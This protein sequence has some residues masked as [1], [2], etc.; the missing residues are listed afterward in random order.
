[1]AGLYSL[2]KGAR[3]QHEVLSRECRTDQYFTNKGWLHL[4]RTPRGF[5]SSLGMR[6]ALEQYG[7]GFDCVDKPE[8]A[9]LEPGLKPIFHS[10][11][12]IRDAAT[13][14]D[15]GA[16]SEALMVRF[17]AQGG[18][19]VHDHV[20]GI[21]PADSGW[22]VVLKQGRIETW[23]LVIAMGVNSGDLLKS[24]GLDVPLYAE[25]GYHQHFVPGGDHRLNRSIFDVESSYVMSPM[26]AG[27]R[28]TSGIEWAKAD[29]KPTPKQL[30]RIVP[31]ARQA[32]ELG[33]A[34]EVEP[35]LGCRPQTADS[36][37]MIG[38]AKPGL[39]VNAGHGHMGFNLGPVSGKVLAQTI[40]GEEPEI[41]LT[42]YSPWRFQ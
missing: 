7:I 2:A 20:I 24:Q 9:E 42:P 41:G 15:P 18:T 22:W 23:Q 33:D 29:A 13:C 39:W 19:L 1:M 14:S 8:I 31:K 25:R 26:Q 34:V 21:Q 17:N 28:V 4:F 6:Q 38:Q 37:P 12:L 11:V 10:G 27:L 3:A 32:M 36:L 30:E 35:W 16:I 40:H 5:E